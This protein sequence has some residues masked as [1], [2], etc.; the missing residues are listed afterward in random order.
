MALSKCV[1]VFKVPRAK[2]K[3]VDPSSEGTSCIAP[4]ESNAL[5]WP[6]FP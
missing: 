1:P 3:A 2:V 4:S 6:T 5:S